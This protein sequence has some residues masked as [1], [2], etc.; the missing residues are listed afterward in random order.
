MSSSGPPGG[1]D[2]DLDQLVALCHACHEQ[3]DAPYAQGRLVI[4]PL[5]AGRF[6][7]TLMRGVGKW[8]PGGRPLG[9]PVASGSR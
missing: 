1:S 3:T 4:T 8:E 6:A 7:F 9:K 5:G 2:F